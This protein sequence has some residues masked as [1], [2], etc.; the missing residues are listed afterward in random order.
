MLLTTS[1]AIILEDLE[2]YL[3]I[4]RLYTEEDFC[5][6]KV[7]TPPEIQRSDLS[8]AVLQLKAFG[9]D[10]VLR[11]DFP[12]PPPAKNLVSALEMLFALGAIDRSGQLTQPLG[13]TM[14]EFPIG[15]MYSKALIAAGKN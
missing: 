2:H 13:M 4:F 11:F 15:P 3:F 14:A 8:M 9:I 7:A 1:D 12:S 10:N 5:K 6:L